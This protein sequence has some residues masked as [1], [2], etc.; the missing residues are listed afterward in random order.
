MNL[1]KYAV[2]TTYMVYKYDTK[3]SAPNQKL[4]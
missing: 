4:K 2:M 3:S 1:Y